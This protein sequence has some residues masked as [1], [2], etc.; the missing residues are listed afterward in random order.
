M[1][2][3]WTF[4]Y[5]WYVAVTVHCDSVSDLH[6]TSTF[7]SLLVTFGMWD[8]SKLRNKNFDTHYNPVTVLMKIPKHMK[9]D[10]RIQKHNS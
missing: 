7:W 10:N 1:Y 5:H 3:G 2:P 8:M 6:V 4:I 9:N